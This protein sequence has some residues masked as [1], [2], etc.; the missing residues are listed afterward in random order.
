M[1]LSMVGAAVC[2][3]YVR[4]RWRRYLGDPPFLW[5]AGA[6]EYK[7]AYD[8]WAGQTLTPGD[9]CTMTT[10]VFTN[11]V[12]TISEETVIG[13]VCW[14]SCDNCVNGYLRASV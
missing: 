7:F 4:W 8:S 5:K 11:R 2:R 9:P 3:A 12:I 13:A 10:D 6:Y 14:G 1:V